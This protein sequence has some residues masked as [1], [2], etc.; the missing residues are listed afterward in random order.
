MD[1]DV[2][3]WQASLAVHEAGHAVVG[4]LFGGEVTELSAS[5]EHR[6]GLSH[7]RYPPTIWEHN[8][9]ILLAGEGAEL[10][11]DPSGKFL[12]EKGTPRAAEDRCRVDNYLSA[13]LD[14][15]G[16]PE[17]DDERI[18]R[19]LFDGECAVKKILDDGPVWHCITRAAAEFL[20]SMEQ[21]KSLSGEEYAK[22]VVPFLSDECIRRVRRGFDF[23]SSNW[24]LP[25]SGWRS[26]RSLPDTRQRA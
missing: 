7:M 19:L 24:N 13:Y 26:W 10:R 1:L 9:M 20:G 16:D 23:P 6:S 11:F 12:H 22:I 17:G 2:S 18:D 8:V 5:L 25:P 4:T 15:F 14:N 3:D 21:G